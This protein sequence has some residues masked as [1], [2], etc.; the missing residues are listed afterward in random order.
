[1]KDFKELLEDSE[2]LHN[3]ETAAKK[4]KEKEKRLH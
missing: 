3:A 4:K 1:L 2:K